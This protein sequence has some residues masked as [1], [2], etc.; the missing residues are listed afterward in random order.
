MPAQGANAIKTA[1]LPPN[2]SESSAALYMKA[3]QA[4]AAKTSAHARREG[5]PSSRRPWTP[6]EEQ[7]LM[8][9]LDMVKGPHWSQIL[10]L[11]GANGSISDI[12]KDRSQVQLK[13]KARNLKLFFLK[14]NSEMP[15][16]L[17]HV[18]GELKTRAPTQAAKKEAEE[19]ARMNTKEDQAHAQGISILANGLQGNGPGAQ[20][21]NMA[22]TQQTPAPSA[23]TRP[24]SVAPQNGGAA[25]HTVARSAAG[26]PQSTG[27]VQNVTARVGQPPQSTAPTAATTH[28]R[29]PV[30]ANTPSAM[31]LALAQAPQSSYAAAKAQ[32]FPRVDSSPTPA[33]IAQ[34]L[35]AARSHAHPQPAASTMQARPQMQA[36]SQQ[37]GRPQAQG[38]SQQTYAQTQGQ[39]RP[40]GQVGASTGN[41]TNTGPPSWASAVAALQAQGK[42]Q[43]NNQAPASHALPQ[44]TMQAHNRLPTAQAAAASSMPT[45]ST[46]AAT[47]AARPAPHITSPPVSRENAASPLEAAI[48]GARGHGPGPPP[49]AMA[50]PA[51]VQPQLSL[52][53]QLAAALSSHNASPAPP[54]A[55]HAVAPSPQ[56]PAKHV[57]SNA[58]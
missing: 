4:A 38:N 40:Q 16:Y 25:P 49:A 51:V 56:P 57:S 44:A 50:S 58:S 35:A 54:A 33:S 23:A 36:Q 12:L 45:P 48:K 46:T 6:E 3:R 34:Q 21:G 20:N 28:Q 10:Q 7:A 18:T 53:A 8:T 42:Q 27:T 13:D 15:Y 47:P 26:P 17:Q 52:E 39:A 37:V 1:I 24:A 19:R 14:T 5:Y 29:G 9:G 31:S 2:Q 11:F 22:R 41:A 43:P 30:T 32:L 55:T